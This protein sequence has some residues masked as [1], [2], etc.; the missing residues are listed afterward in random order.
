MKMN[1]LQENKKLKSIVLL[2]TLLYFPFTLEFCYSLGKLHSVATAFSHSA[3]T[4][5]P[6]IPFAVISTL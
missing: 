4:L 2:Y 3:W 6:M 5:L 1:N